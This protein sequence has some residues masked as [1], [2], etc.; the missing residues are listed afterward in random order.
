MNQYRINDNGKYEVRVIYG[1]E[2]VRAYVDG[3][4]FDPETCDK[5]IYVVR[6]FN[7]EAEVHAYFKGVD[8][9]DGWESSYTLSG[10]ERNP[11][12]TEVKQEG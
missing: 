1:R 8:D 9:M 7:S 10:C 6:E 4:T 11:D 2:M 3:E 12:E 5:G